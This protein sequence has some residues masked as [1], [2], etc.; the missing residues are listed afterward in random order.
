MRCR[1]AALLLVAGA[2]C[3]CGG[4]PSDVEQV[5]DVVEAF[6]KATAAKDYQR[7]CD[8]LLAPKLVE[9]VES[10][11]LPCEVALKQGLGDVVSP[12]LTVGE[13]EVRGNTATADVRSAAA[14][15]QPSRDTLQ[16]VQVE[17]SWRIA[18]LR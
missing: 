9:E 18:S 11:G 14:G 1:L 3:G 4:G 16:L 10:V 6:G 17:D 2:A 8:H 13:I 5:H 12:T 7:L 15:E